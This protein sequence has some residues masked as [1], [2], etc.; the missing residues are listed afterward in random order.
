MTKIYELPIS[1]ITAIITRSL[2]GQRADKHN[3]E[4]CLI[5]DMTVTVPVPPDFI[6][7]GHN[8]WLNQNWQEKSEELEI[9]H[10]VFK[11]VMV[12]A[13]WSQKNLSTMIFYPDSSSQV[14]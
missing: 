10:P 5:P 12:S 6:L 13:T 11:L 9:S 4:R 14:M 7:I 2:S 8:M 3:C 1:F